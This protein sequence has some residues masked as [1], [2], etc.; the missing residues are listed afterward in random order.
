MRKANQGAQR[1]TPVQLYRERRGGPS[2]RDGATP[3]LISQRTAAITD[4]LRS[5]QSQRVG[6]QRTVSSRAGAIHVPNGRNGSPREVLAPARL[7]R[8]SAQR[9]ADTWGGPGQPHRAHR[10]LGTLVVRA[11]LDGH[12]VVTATTPAVRDR[13]TG[14]PNGAYRTHRRNRREIHACAAPRVV[15]TQCPARHSAKGDRTPSPAVRDAL[16]EP[17]RP[18][19]SHRQQS[20]TGARPRTR[21]HNMPQPGA[22]RYHDDSIAHQRHFPGTRCLPTHWVTRAL[23]G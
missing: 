1:A 2:R 3:H 5:T 12:S 14:R 6:K 18:R 16:R 17:T 15:P 9:S 4:K 10:A 7:A 13:H 20:A 21:R 11:R 8:T 22:A 23:S 19:R